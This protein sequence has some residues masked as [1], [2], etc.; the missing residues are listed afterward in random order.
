MR[1]CCMMILVGVIFIYIYLFSIIIDSN[2]L[3]SA[4]VI[5]AHNCFEVE[6]DT[7]DSVALKHIIKNVDK[8]NTFYGAIVKYTTITQRI[9]G[10]CSLVVNQTCQL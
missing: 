3:S 6:Q 8:Y 1:D 4:P 9:H 7:I 10:K 5:I 2:I